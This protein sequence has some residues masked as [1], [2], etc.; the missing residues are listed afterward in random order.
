[1]QH[2]DTPETAPARPTL[3]DR[4]GALGARLHPATWPV[5]V[6][7]LGL[8]RAVIPHLVDPNESGNP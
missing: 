2:E 4:V 6:G 8:V 5:S 1:M 3:A 7:V